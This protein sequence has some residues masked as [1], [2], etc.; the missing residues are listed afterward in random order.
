MSVLQCL[1]AKGEE[2][3]KEAAVQEAAVDPQAVH[4]PLSFMRGQSS[5]LSLCCS[6]SVLIMVLLIDMYSKQQQ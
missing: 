6:S 5:G 2:Q 3:H 4:S 1:V